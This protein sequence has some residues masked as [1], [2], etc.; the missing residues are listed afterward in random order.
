MDKYSIMLKNIFLYIK[1]QYNIILISSLQYFNY[2]FLFLD[3]NII[4]IFFTIINI[5]ILF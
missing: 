3:K 2:I 1:T 5:K 4:Y